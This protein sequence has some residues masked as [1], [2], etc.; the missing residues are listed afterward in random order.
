MIYFLRGKAATGK[1]TLA[2]IVHD[3]YKLPI[4]KKDDIFDIVFSR[5]IDVVEANAISYDLL[6]MQ[7]QQLDHSKIDAVVDIGLSHTPTF[8]S[9]INKMNLSK[10]TFILCTCSDDQ[11]WASRIQARID[12]PN[13]LPNQMF[14]STKEAFEHYHKYDISALAS[15]YILDSALSMETLESK[16]IDI[17]KKNRSE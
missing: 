16:L 7:I 5:G 4:L 3:K 11:I 2:G 13:P 17:I 12:H 14:V 8:T 6:A 10:S 15:E 1:S 9:F